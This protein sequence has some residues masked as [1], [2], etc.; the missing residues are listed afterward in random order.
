MT[1]EDKKDR[2]IMNTIGRLTDREQDLVNMAY[3]AGRDESVS[4]R[5][6]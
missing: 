4:S 3:K 5:Q 2:T 6:P 1:P